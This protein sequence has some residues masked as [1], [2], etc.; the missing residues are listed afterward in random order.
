MWAAVSI[1]FDEVTL[2][3]KGEIQITAILLLATK[4]IRADGFYKQQSQVEA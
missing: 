3:S 4:I 2:S 1:V